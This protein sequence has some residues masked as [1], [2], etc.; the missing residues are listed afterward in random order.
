MTVLSAVGPFST[1][2]SSCLKFYSVLKVL[3]NKKGNQALSTAQ[4]QLQIDLQLHLDLVWSMERE[5]RM[6]KINEADSKISSL[7]LSMGEAKKTLPLHFP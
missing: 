1:N 3:D 5:K 6:V 4:N 7:V 2:S